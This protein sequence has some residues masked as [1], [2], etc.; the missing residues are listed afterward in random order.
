MLIHVVWNR[1]IKIPWLG[2]LLAWTSVAMTPVD[3]APYIGLVIGSLTVS[4]GNLNACVGLVFVTLAGWGDYDRLGC[5][6]RL[7]HD[8]LE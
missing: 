7:N 6:G 2:L 3:L 1:W 4:P 8:R 5:W